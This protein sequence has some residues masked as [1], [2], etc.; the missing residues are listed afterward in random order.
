MKNAIICNK[1][2][3][4]QSDLANM[5]AT[6]GK[7]LFLKSLLSKI[8]IFFRKEKKI[9]LKMLKSQKNCMYQM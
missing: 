6:P 5:I 9:T 8:F 1:Q 7:E 2:T 4:K 3:K